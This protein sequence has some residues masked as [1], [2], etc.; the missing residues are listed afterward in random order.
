MAFNSKNGTYFWSNGYQYGTVVIDATDTEKA[1]TLTS[2]NGNLVLKSF[3]LNGF[4][5]IKF[6][7]EKRFSKDENIQ[8]K[9]SKQ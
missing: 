6:K 9:I 4:S 7:I 5:S 2:K 1:I 8:L 3:K